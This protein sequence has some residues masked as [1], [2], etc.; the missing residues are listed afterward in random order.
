M[1]TGSN[2]EF[3]PILHLDVLRLNQTVD[4]SE[5]YDNI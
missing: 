2:W 5:K 4:F 1:I 3:F